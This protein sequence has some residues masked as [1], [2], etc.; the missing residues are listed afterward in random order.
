VGGEVAIGAGDG[1]I[2]IP[3]LN[4]IKNEFVLKFYLRTR[5]VR[6]P[7]SIVVD[8]QEKRKKGA[9]RCVTEILRHICDI[10]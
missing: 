9:I 6:M 7:I 1:V 4:M 3:F 8:M 2:P 5:L 10:S